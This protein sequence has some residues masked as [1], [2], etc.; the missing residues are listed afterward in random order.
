MTEESIQFHIRS[1]DYF[2]TLATVL[3]LLR[4]D[5]ARGY[6][7]RHDETLQRLR[8]DLVYLQDRCRIVAIAGVS[9]SAPV[10]A[11]S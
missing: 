5:A 7:Q 8:D 2:G 10:D 11:N 1:N 4:Q 3:D 9:S 6:T